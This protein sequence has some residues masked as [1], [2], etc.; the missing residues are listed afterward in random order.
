M[1]ATPQ[2]AESPVGSTAG[3]QPIAA[4]AASAG[5]GEAEAETA[6]EAEV[7]EATPAVEEVQPEEAQVTASPNV[8]L[9]SE[10]RLTSR[11]VEEANLETPEEGALILDPAITGTQGISTP[12]DD[13]P[14]SQTFP[15]EED[16]GEALASLATLS[17]HLHAQSLKRRMS[18]SF[19]EEGPAA[20]LLRRE[21]QSLRQASPPDN[22]NNQQQD[23]PTTDNN[24][25]RSP[26]MAMPIHYQHMSPVMVAHT[27]MASDHNPYASSA[28]AMFQSGVSAQLAQAGS[29]T[30]NHPVGAPYIPGYATSAVSYDSPYAGNQQSNNW[31]IQGYT[32]NMP[33]N[34]PG[35]G[36]SESGRPYMDRSVSHEE[37]MRMGGSLDM[38]GGPGGQGLMNAGIG[39]S[40][41]GGESS[42]RGNGIAEDAFN[43]YNPQDQ[44]VHDLNASDSL[45]NLHSGGMYPVPMSSSQHGQDMRS[46]TLQ[47]PSMSVGAHMDHHHHQG[48]GDDDGMN[49]ML[50]GANGKLRDEK[51]RKRIVQAC[52]PCRIRKAKCNGQQPCGRCGSRCLE[53]R[54]APER[55]MRGPNKVK[56]SQTEKEQANRERQ[57]RKAAERHAQE[58]A[59]AAAAVAIQA[60]SN[61][62]NQHMHPHQQHPNMIDD[63]IQI[64]SATGPIDGMRQQ[65]SPN[66]SRGDI[67][68]EPE[69]MSRSLLSAYDAS[70][71]NPSS[72]SLH[73]HGQ[74]LSN[75]PGGGFSMNQPHYLEGMSSSRDYDRSDRTTDQRGIF[76]GGQPATPG[77]AG[78]GGQADFNGGQY[79]N[80]GAYGSNPAVSASPP[81]VQAGT[82]YPR[83]Y[84]P[85]SKSHRSPLISGERELDYDAIEDAAATADHSP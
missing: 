69:G 28:S 52:E 3:S 15:A 79:Q 59:E 45:L 9:D 17:A 27:H 4:R 21:D 38:G 19:E 10:P 83:E 7:T 71:S 2:E 23:Q 64:T 37:H 56:K 46:A 67:K 20:K 58:M 6:V 29:P 1:S 33:S 18:R 8:P 36:L 47:S 62:A 70:N 22:E 72:A 53:C 85:P 32:T 26:V 31:N 14:E 82:S 24:M 5:A 34:A 74:L 49:P 39:G 16:T 41:Y 84:Y 61:A 80:L 42:I 30:D 77:S 81:N 66:G 11:V 40:G 44:G 50:G 57:Q 63:E 55:K 78:V 35:M 13:A 43:L 65:F 51:Q 60:V 54:Y 48:S 73:Q 68:D 76:Y 75:W 12:A 25:L